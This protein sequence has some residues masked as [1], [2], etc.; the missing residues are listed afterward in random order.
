MKKIKTVNL[1]LDIL[2]EVLSVE[3]GMY[4]YQYIKGFCDIFFK[5]Y[6]QFSLLKHLPRHPHTKDELS[7]KEAKGDQR[8]KTI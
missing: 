2:V 6:M 8:S 3:D 5:Y 1:I 4:W 7:L